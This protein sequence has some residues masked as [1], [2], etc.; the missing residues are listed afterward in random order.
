[1]VGERDSFPLAWYR[2]YPNSEERMNVMANREEN[3]E[4]VSEN[5]IS[6]RKAREKAVSQTIANMKALS[7]FKDLSEGQWELIRHYVML[8]FIDGKDYAISKYVFKDDHS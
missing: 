2:K 3:E 8:A 6:Y 5:V 4:A 7:S 1:M